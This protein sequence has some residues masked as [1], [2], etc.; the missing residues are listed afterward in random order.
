M[1]MKCWASS[2]S[3]NWTIWPLVTA[4]ERRDL[5][6]QEEVRVVDVVERDD[7]P[8][9]DH[10]T[11]VRVVQ[12]PQPVSRTSTTV[13]TSLGGS[14][15]SGSASAGG[16]ILTGTSALLIVDEGSDVLHRSPPT[17]VARFTGELRPALWF[18]SSD[19]RSQRRHHTV[20]WGRG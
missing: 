4:G 10:D 3:W 1:S 12:L 9:V 11:V 13:R 7:Q 15:A 20:D 19:A 8:R 14:G 2:S 18:A 6:R 16:E 17:R 5:A